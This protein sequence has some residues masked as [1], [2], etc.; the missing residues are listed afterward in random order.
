MGVNRKA[1]LPLNGKPLL[2]HVTGRLQPQLGALLLSLEGETREFDNYGLP[3]IPDLLPH[4]RGPLMGL[5]SALKYLC[6]GG[7]DSALVVCPCD[8]PFIPA[9]LVTSLL[10]AAD[11]DDKK[12]VVIISYQGV[13]QPTF[14]LWQRH[15]LPI[16]QTAAIDQGQGGIKQLLSA[17]PYVLVEWPEAEPPPFFNVNTPAD[18]EAAERWLG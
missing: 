13:L 15:H 9:D 16:I 5:Y 8:A 12:P 11:G 7:E 10:N 1:L 6:D 18:L 3:V 17:L 2:E 14:S 4:Y